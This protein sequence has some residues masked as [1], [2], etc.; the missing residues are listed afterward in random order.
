MQQKKRTISPKFIN[1][2]FQPKALDFKM[3]AEVS[4]ILLLLTAVEVKTKLC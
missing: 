2:R 1:V 3:L 4:G